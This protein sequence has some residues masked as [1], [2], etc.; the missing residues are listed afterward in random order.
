MNQEEFNDEFIQHRELIE[1]MNVSKCFFDTYIT[2]GRFPKPI[3]VGATKLWHK[4][5]IKN[6][7]FLL[8][9]GVIL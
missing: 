9:R 6:H 4:Q 3:R 8:E 5:A 7:Y 2:D 1:T